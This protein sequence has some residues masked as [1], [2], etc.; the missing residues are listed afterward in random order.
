MLKAL[1]KAARRFTQT[2]ARL[3][4]EARLE[5]CLPH[6]D[7]GEI[8]VWDVSKALPRRRHWRGADIRPEGQK[9]E[10]LYVHHSVGAGK[11]DFRGVRGSV[12]HVMERRKEK[13]P[14]SGY[15]FWI[16]RLP[17][18]DKEGRL[19]IFRMAEDSYRAWHS[20]KKANDHGIGIAFQGNYSQEPPPAEMFLC[21]TALFTWL[22]QRYGLEYADQISLHNEAGIHGGSPK[23][24]CPGPH[25]TEW[26]KAMRSRLPERGNDE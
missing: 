26:I 20:G 12:I 7:G 9:F 1:A 23:P 4:P 18:Y 3:P 5:L 14:G 21:A 8:A 22:C 6:P 25:I 13:F 16:P 10:R 2:S 15:H 17:V 11:P 19:V 24:A